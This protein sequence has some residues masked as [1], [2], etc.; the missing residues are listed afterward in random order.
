MRYLDRSNWPHV[1]LYWTPPGR[2]RQ[3]VP[4]QNLFVSETAYTQAAAAAPPRRPQR[5]RRLRRGPR[6]PPTPKPTPRPPSAI[7]APQFQATWGQ[8][9]TAE[10]EFVEPRDMALDSTGNLYVVDYGNQRIVKFDAK[11]QFLVA[12]GTGGEFRDLFAVAVD[13]KDV[14]YALDANT[15]WILKFRPDGG[16]IGR[17]DIGPLSVFNPRGLAVDKDGLVY[18]ADTGGGRVLKLDQEGRL[19][20]AWGSRGA[21]ESQF[22]EPSALAVGAD[23]AIYA[24]DANNNRVQV[25]S[26]DGRFQ[27]AWPVPGAA[28]ASTARVWPLDKAGNLYVSDPRGES[29]ARPGRRGSGSRGMGQ[30]GGRP[31]PV[32]PAYRRGRGAERRGLRGRYE[33]SPDTEIR[34]GAVAINYLRT[35]RAQSC[36]LLYIPP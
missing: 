31:R 9:G 27:A 24:A 15:G 25:F 34:A 30:R 4:S 11:G 5:P 26:A 18:V 28:A 22:N 32:R 21:G 20:T 35:Q 23:G 16:Y 3:I 14:L 1:Y 10:G 2:E 7:R 12:L 13:A 8:R 29:A 36:L 33:E 19:L 6:S 17:L